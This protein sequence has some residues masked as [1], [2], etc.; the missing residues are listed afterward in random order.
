[1]ENL[2]IVESPAKA[3]TL[4]RF[5]GDQYRVEASMGHLVDLPKSKMGIAVDGN[6]AP[7]YQVMK[8]KD[9]RVKELE[10]MAKEAKNLYLAT[11]PDREGEA[12]SWHL[13]NLFAAPKSDKD[14][15]L[16]TKQAS[17]LKVPYKRVV[18]HEITKSAVEAAFASPR[19]IDDDLV[20]A[21]QARRVLDRVVG[22]KLSPLL[23]RKVRI[24]L[25]AGR[26]QSVALRIIVD[27][28]R[29][30]AAFVPQEYWSIAVELAKKTAKGSKLLETFIAQL[31]EKDGKKVEIKNKAQ[32]DAIIAD[33]DGRSYIVKDVQQKQSKRSPYPPF[34]TSTMQQAAANTMG[35]TAKKTMKL[36]QDLYEEGYIT[37]MRTDSFNL[38]QSAIAQTREF[39]AKN[40]GEQYLPPGPKFYTTKS[41]VA[42]EAHEAIRPTN[43]N[44]S[45]DEIKKVGKDH[46]RLYE[47]IWKRMVACQMADAL[48]DQTTVDITAQA[49]KQKAEKAENAEYLFRANGSRI[50]FPGWLLA[51][52][53]G[54]QNVK[55]KSKQ[56]IDEEDLPYEDKLLPKLETEEPLDFQK[57]V[58]EQ[59]FTQPPP[60]YTEASLIKALEANEIGRPSTYAPIISTIMDR[61]YV[62]KSERKLVPTAVGFAVNDFLVA[63]FP[64]IVDVAFT[65]K[66][67]DELDEVANGK[68]DWIAMMKEFY[69]PFDKKVET[70]GE[71]SERVKIEA[72]DSGEKCPKCGKPLLIRTGRFGRFL[73]CSG[74]PDCD[75]KTSY[76]EKIDMKCPDCKVGEV[77]IK[78]THRGR[79]FYGCSTYPKCKFAS[80]N[81][82]SK[83]EEKTAPEQTPETA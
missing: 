1:M 79:P 3:R 12:I 4:S 71:K 36:A 10:K 50:K 14:G 35:F 70:V 47:L 23:W 69:K 55:S 80:W 9:K 30:I 52:S 11:D 15:I 48:Y 77:V 6:F 13:L 73:G 42:Q 81:D 64:D 57:L 29:E 28:E 25:S 46:F 43:V 78:Y 34:T 2:V 59:H 83:S 62:E 58:P 5:L 17:A 8:D 60:R 51:F 31:I 65:A 19:Q 45:T 27:R 18:F 21:Q 38:A 67:E 40:Y 56:E 75:Y 53:A 37:Y 49:G 54:K 7:Q 74:F 16:A 68:V 82:P 44:A 33:L 72:P 24:G 26:V 22:Y 66:M 39:I 61:R 41:K 63:N 20:D 32:S 76:Q